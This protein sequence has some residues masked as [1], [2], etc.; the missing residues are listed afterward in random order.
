[1]FGLLAAQ[2]PQLVC[3]EIDDMTHDISP[4]EHAIFTSH[5][6]ARMQ[7][8]LHRHSSSMNLAGTVYFS[9]DNRSIMERVPDLSM[10][11]DTMLFYFRNE[12][13]GAGPCMPTACEW[14]PGEST[15]PPIDRRQGGCLAGACAETTVANVAEEVREIAAWLPRGRRF[16]VG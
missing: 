1:V 5:V 11:G 6:V 12:K 4:A 16:V 13:Q 2:Y 3:L 14:G 10:L 9:E 7:A 15:L 8:N